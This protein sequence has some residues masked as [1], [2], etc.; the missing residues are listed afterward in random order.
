MFNKDAFA[1]LINKGYHFKGES[2]QIG[3]WYFGRRGCTRNA[4]IFLP[5]KQ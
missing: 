2:V 4:A 1:D 5:L 3:V